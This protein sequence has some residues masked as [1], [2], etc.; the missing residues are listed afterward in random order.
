MPIHMFTRMGLWDESVASNLASAAAAEKRAAKMHPG[1]GSFDELHA[2]D[3]LVYAW[4]QQAQDDR[5]RGMLGEMRTM[6][7][8]DDPQ[9]AAAYAFAAAPVRY[10]LERHDWKAAATLEIWPAWFPWSPHPHAR[11]I[12]EFGRALG[13]ARTGDLAGAQQTIDS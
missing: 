11:A 2:D 10:A 13:C 9:L 12:P 4:L 3:Y 5:A 1:A 6:T 8:V 7:K